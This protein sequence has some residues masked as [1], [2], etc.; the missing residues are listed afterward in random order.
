MS[1]S[2]VAAECVILSIAGSTCD[3]CG[4]TDS[5]REVAAWLSVYYAVAAL[6]IYPDI[7][8]ATST[9]VI[10]CCFGS[11]L[12]VSRA[13]SLS[14]NANGGSCAANSNLQSNFNQLA[15]S[16]QSDIFRVLAAGW[17]GNHTSRIES[18]INPGVSARRLWRSY[19][20]R[21]AA[22]KSH[23]GI[24]IGYLRGNQSLLHGQVAWHGNDSHS[25]RRVTVQCQPRYV[26]LG[27][28]GFTGR[29]W[30]TTY[31]SLKLN[32]RRAALNSSHCSL[33]LTLATGI[34]SSR[35]T[36]S[37]V[38][39]STARCVNYCNSTDPYSKSNC[40]VGHKKV[41]WL[42][43]PDALLRYRQKIQDCR[44]RSSVHNFRLFPDT[45]QLFTRRK[46]KHWTL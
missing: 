13:T 17:H 1:L 10:G 41:K 8:C 39:L 18:A 21:T 45:V 7:L 11:V 44:L 25:V 33:R 6:R 4:W 34:C 3:G 19:D 15:R 20:N 14:K 40:S 30:S 42:C 43:Y 32:A 27:L 2:F 16:S 37:R 24:D 36:I 38:E 9:T 22:T 26:P 31:R 5:V 35:I 23:I 12:V 28:R 29:A 46:D